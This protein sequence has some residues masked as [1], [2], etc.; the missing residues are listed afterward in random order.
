MR[1][2]VSFTHMHLI[3]IIYSFQNIISL[4]FSVFKCIKLLIPKYLKI[5]QKND[6]EKETIYNLWF[7]FHFSI[8]KGIIASLV[9]VV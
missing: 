2:H 1:F 3:G 4:L 5:K 6:K 9:P 7:F 8:Y